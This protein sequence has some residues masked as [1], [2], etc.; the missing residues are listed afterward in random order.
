MLNPDGTIY[1]ENLRKARATDT[2]TFK[3][4]GTETWEPTFTFHGFR[5]AELTGFPG[6][7]GPQMLTAIAVGSDTPIAG[8][9]ECSNPILNKL[10]S[11][12]VWGQRGNFLSVPT[13]CPQRDE[14]LGWMGDAQVFIRTATCNCDVREFFNNWL[15]EVA[16]AQSK[17]GAFSDVSP[18]VAAGEGIAAWADAGV[19]C[20]WTIYQVYG[21]T[22]LLARQYPSMVDFIEYCRDHSKDLIRPADGYGDWLSIAADTPK[23]V[24]ATA[25]F[26]HSTDLVAQS[27]AI[28]GKTDDAEKYRDLFNQIR[29]AFNKKF[30]A[31]N[32]RIEGDT[33]TCYLLALKFDLLDDAKKT[34]AVKY[35]VQDIAKKHDHLSTGF[36]GVGY[37]LPILTQFGHADVAYRLINQDTFPSWLFPVKNGATTIWERWDGWTPDKGFQTPTMN[38]FNH[39]SLGSCGQWMYQTIAGIDFGGQDPAFKHIIIRPI[40]GGGLTWAAASYESPYGP[41][42]S[43]WE[44]SGNQLKLSVTIPANTTATIFVPGPHGADVTKGREGVERMQ[45]HPDSAELEVGSGDY[46]FVA[47]Q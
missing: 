30:V 34:L 9:W 16:D 42:K 14:R 11:N 44:L 27:A 7:V 21:D 17:E 36:V 8:A 32:G 35:L 26:A 5:Y 28:L 12:I 24:L 20:P 19:I 13:D 2:Y 33:Q 47:Q 10:Y 25:Y 40:P 37:L 4:D 45:S 6:D 38:S 41:I 31:D 29:A 15:I 22:R 46:V 43:R 23:D 3:G 1:T 39:Y 18:R